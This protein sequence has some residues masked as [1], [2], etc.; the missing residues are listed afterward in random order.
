MHIVLYTEIDFTRELQTHTHKKNVKS[1]C[2]PGS[3]V[4]VHTGLPACPTEQVLGARAST[5]EGPP[6]VR[7]ALY[8]G[9]QQGPLRVLA[10]LSVCYGTALIS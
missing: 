10:C 9:H 3:D 4:L 1:Q 8:P 7:A 5:G 2:T 6:E